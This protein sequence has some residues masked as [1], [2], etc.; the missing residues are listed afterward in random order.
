MEPARPY[1]VALCTLCRIYLCPDASDPPPDSPLQPVF[2]EALLR[3]IRRRDE[4]ASPSL[5]ELLR[6]V[7]VGAGVEKELGGIHV[8]C[9]CMGSLRGRCDGLAALRCLHCC[10]PSNIRCLPCGAPPTPAHPTQDQVCPHG[11]EASPE[12]DFFGA[13]KAGVGQRLA[14]LE[15]PDDLVAFFG[16]LAEGVITS[17]TSAPAEGEDGGADAS[18]ALGVYLRMVYARYTA[19]S[20]EVGGSKGCA[21]PGAW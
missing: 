19:M 9:W 11:D 2:G 12:A 15:T 3:E 20:F 13:V 5:I 1:D 17:A 14:L 21:W 6:R 7:Q 8:Q 10:V 4:A 16:A 18:S